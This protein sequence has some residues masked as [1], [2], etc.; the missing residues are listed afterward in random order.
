MV[1]IIVI[2][3]IKI[4]RGLWKLYKYVQYMD[5]RSDHEYFIIKYNMIN[6][7]ESL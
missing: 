3:Q 5:T 6:K 1:I 7:L 4:V 2:V